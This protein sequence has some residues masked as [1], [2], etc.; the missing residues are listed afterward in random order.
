ML[1]PEIEMVGDS[2]CSGCACTFTN[3]E[4]LRE[5]ACSCD[6]WRVR[7]SVGADLVGA[8]IRVHGTK[9]RGRAARVVITVILDDVVFGLRRV[10]P[11]VDS[12][13]GA[14]ARSAVLGRVGDRSDN[15]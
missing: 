15:R 1:R 14:G 7:P 6:R 3:G 2:H 11:A 5:R 9:A 13:V 12:Q 8:S 4:V 10:D